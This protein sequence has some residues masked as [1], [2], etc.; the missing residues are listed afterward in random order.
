MKPFSPEHHPMNA[1]VKSGAATQVQALGVTVTVPASGYAA[2]QN[3]VRAPSVSSGNFTHTLG[4][5]QPSKP[6]NDR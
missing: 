6:G 5:N 2:S 1:H 3:G 4:R